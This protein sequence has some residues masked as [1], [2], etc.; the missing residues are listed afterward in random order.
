MFFFKLGR[1]A[2]KNTLGMQI[3]IIILIS[4]E[5]LAPGPAK[6]DLL[7]SETYSTQSKPEGMIAIF[8]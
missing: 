4:L 6:P 2:F 5:A 3:P 7:I 1:Q 8:I